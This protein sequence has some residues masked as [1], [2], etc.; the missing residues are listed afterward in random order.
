M[1]FGPLGRAPSRLTGGVASSV[2]DCGLAT[3]DSTVLGMPIALFTSFLL[4]VA[5]T[6]F[7]G[8]GKEAIARRS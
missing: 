4:L 1:P 7:L 2:R 3:W 8:H 5:R 6:A